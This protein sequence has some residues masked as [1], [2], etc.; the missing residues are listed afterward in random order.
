MDQNNN[1]STTP[2]PVPQAE[3]NVPVSAPASVTPAPEVVK[4]SEGGKDKKKLLF[5]ALFAVIVLVIL[6]IVGYYLYSTM[7]SKPVEEAPVAAVPTQEPVVTPVPTTDPNAIKD[8][9]ELDSVVKDIDSATDE[10][11][12]TQ[13]V[14]GLRTDS[15]F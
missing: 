1:Q 11:S 9:S 12:M 2:S 10:A 5:L 4:S 15:N 3:T 14:N 6:G 8:G 7:T 13:E